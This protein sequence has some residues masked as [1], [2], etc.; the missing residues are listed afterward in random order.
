MNPIQQE[1]KHRISPGA[2]GDEHPQPS[3]DF[4]QTSWNEFGRRLQNEY[5]PIFEPSSKPTKS[6]QEKLAELRQFSKEFHLLP[7]K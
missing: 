1:L 7:P 3:L 4:Q 2:S 6:K 5:I